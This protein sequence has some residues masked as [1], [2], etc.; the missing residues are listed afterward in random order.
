MK[1]RLLV[2][3][4][5]TA[6]TLFVFIFHILIFQFFLLLLLGNSL[7]ADVI[8]FEFNPP[9]GTSFVETL[10][11]TQSIK[12]GLPQPMSTSDISKTRYVIKKT[13]GGYYVNTIPI[14]PSNLK[15]S[16][17]SM[18]ALNSLIS[19]LQLDYELNER[20]QL[21]RVL[22]VEKAEKKL[23]KF[24]PSKMLETL[25]ATIYGSPLT[26]KQFIERHWTQKEL[27][28]FMVGT[29][30]EL[31]KYYYSKLLLPFYGGNNYEVM[32]RTKAE[33]FKNCDE[34]EPFCIYLRTEMKS[35]DTEYLD[36]LGKTMRKIVIDTFKMFAANVPGVSDKELNIAI[37]EVPFFQF[38][39][40]EITA[41]Y[42]RLLDVKTGLAREM[43]I[44][45]RI[46]ANFAIKPGDES[47]F[48]ITHHTYSAYDYD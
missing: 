23:N 29:N 4:E 36:Y 20:G 9:D 14:K 1:I 47:A 37:N 11:Y 3:K 17:M 18:N 35:T 6:T 22:G 40:P 15:T 16:D 44:K 2:V 25:L 5:R 10:E 45:Q 31:N 34:L 46:K 39:K 19:N 30:M 12:E 43:S 48:V 13:S 28:G 42:E 21:K 32:L 8:T 24:I 26:I 27:T 38:T 7:A 33:R 41:L